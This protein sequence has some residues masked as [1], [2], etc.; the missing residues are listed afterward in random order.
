MV[1][2]VML[3]NYREALVNVRSTLAVHHCSMRRKRCEDKLHQINNEKL[4]WAEAA[5]CGLRISPRQA[6]K[7]TANMTLIPATTRLFR[8]SPRVK[9]YPCT[10][11]P[12]LVSS[13]IYCC[14]TCRYAA[15]GM[16]SDGTKAVLILSR[17]SRIALTMRNHYT[18]TRT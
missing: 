7:C 13:E 18:T 10:T 8:P 5:C 14:T 1:C 17:S 16:R 15:V 4:G 2:V 11:T 3:N 9:V 12:I 6:F